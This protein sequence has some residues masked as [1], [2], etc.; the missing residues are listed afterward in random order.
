MTRGCA[1]ALMGATRAATERAAKAVRNV[2]VPILSSLEPLKFS[3]SKRLRMC[4]QLDAKL[5]EPGLGGKQVR[6][7][8]PFLLRLPQQICRVKHSHSVDGLRQALATIEQP[9]AAKFHDAVLAF[10]HGVSG[11]LA[12]KQ[13]QFRLRELD[14]ALH[15]RQ[16]SHDLALSRVAIAWGAPIN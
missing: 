2:I 13:Q 12:Q 3:R 9:P 16:T 5:P 1:L 10:E 4:A 8:Q 14:Q 15:K 11:R 7:G 6:P